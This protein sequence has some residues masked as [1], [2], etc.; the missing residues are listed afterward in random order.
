MSEHLSEKVL[1]KRLSI[2]HRTLQRWR[3]ER[4]GPGYLKLGHRVVYPVEM[5]EQWEKDCRK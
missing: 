4:I 2:S 1:A 3:Q 5:I